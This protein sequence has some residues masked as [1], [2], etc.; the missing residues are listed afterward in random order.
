MDDNGPTLYSLQRVQNDH[1]TRLSLLEKQGERQQQ[2]LDEINKGIKH[3]VW[4]VV[5]ALVVA[6]VQF[7]LRGGF[8]A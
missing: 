2:A 4:L 1:A 3:L 6:V 7:A 5:A 8:N